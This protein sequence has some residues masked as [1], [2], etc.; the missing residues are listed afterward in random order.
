LPIK[1]KNMLKNNFYSAFT[2]IELLVVITIIGILASVVLVQFPTTTNVARDSRIVSAM[3]QARTIMSTL[4]TLDGN[5]SRFNC[6][7]P[8]MVELCNEVSNNQK[9]SV[10]TRGLQIRAN[11]NLDPPAACM[12]AKLNS[13]DNYW[14]CIDSQGHAGYTN[15]NPDHDLYCRDTGSAVCPPVY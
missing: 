12:Y 10:G 6:S 7:Y 9:F 14:Y 1:I 8:D 13:K 3:A 4:Y 2:L 5:F 11:N 15:T